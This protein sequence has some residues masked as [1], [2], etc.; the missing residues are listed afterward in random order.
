MFSGLVLA[1][2]EENGTTLSPYHNDPMAPQSEVDAPGALA[3]VLIAILLS[4]VKADPAV[5]DL[6]EH[7][8]NVL[9]FGACYQSLQEVY[10]F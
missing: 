8:A 4:T 2:L 3:A 10:L 7:I 5:A 9:P 1:I 6:R